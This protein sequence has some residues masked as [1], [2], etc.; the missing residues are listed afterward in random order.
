V[1]TGPP[2]FRSASSRILP[3]CYF[4]WLAER[5]WLHSRWQ[6]RHTRQAKCLENGLGNASDI[7]GW[8]LLTSLSF[9]CT[10]SPLGRYGWRARLAFYRPAWKAPGLVCIQLF[11]LPRLRTGMLI[12]ARDGNICTRNCSLHSP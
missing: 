9:S 6:I 4:L 5:P 7:A 8:R 10:A 12:Q 2:N 11:L 1:N 3:C